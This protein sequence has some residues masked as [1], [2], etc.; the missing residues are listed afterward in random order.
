MIVN[1]YLNTIATIIVNITNKKRI[2]KKIFFTENND[3]NFANK[4]KCKNKF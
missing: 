1:I 2:T 4:Q 3:K